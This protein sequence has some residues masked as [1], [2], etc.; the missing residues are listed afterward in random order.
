VRKIDE[1]YPANGRVILHV[2]MNAFYCSVHEAEEPDK[3]RGKPTAVAGSVELRKGVIVTSSYAARRLGISTGMLVNQAL[4]K[5]PN[6]IVISPDFHAYRKYS[7]AFMN[8]AYS[9][10]PC[11]EATSIDECYLDISGSKQ[12]GSPLE[13]ATEI[14]KRI[15]KE[16]SLP[17][18]I[19]IAPNKLLAKM[20][21]DMKKPN[22]LTIL[23]IRDVPK[24]LWDKPCGE[25]F[26]IGG[27]T[28]DKLR[29]LNIHTIGQLAKADDK[30]LKQNFGVL[31]VWMKQ[32]A[33]GIDHSPVLEER[34]QSKSIG[35]TTTLPE[36]IC[37]K[38]DV[39]RVL[40]N[41]SD[42]VARR[43]RRKQL[44]AGGVQITIR[45]PDMKTITRTHTLHA[46]TDITEEIYEEACLL[47]SEH[48]GWKKPVR[49]LG[50]T[51]QHLMSKED[52]AI[53]LDL[54]NYQ[55]QPKKESL[56]KAMDILRNKF[57]ENAVLTAGMLGDDP[58]VLIRNHKVR[59]TSLQMDFRDK[60][61]ENLS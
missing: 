39:H 33:N 11:M 4:K 3:Y 52:A 17:C 56:T 48:W 23:R 34:E 12:F 35:H 19:G 27:K 51:L 61:N 13:I 16:L 9:Y 10:T 29:K 21:S 6:L 7:N 18:S 46:P 15:Y 25:L 38:E 53:Q 49:L 50:V 1:Y 44:V 31:G 58:S 37:T 47:Y 54:F 5:C 26:G 45:T 14:Q 41:L 24:V 30:L 28:A 20:A 55:K 36:D 2:D 22:G 42:Q 43:L 60:N 32:A 57:G 8:I 40:L 59:G